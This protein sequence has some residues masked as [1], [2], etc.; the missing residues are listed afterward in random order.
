M[1]KD[2]VNVCVCVSTKYK[3]GFSAV[4]V[5]MVLMYDL[6][7]HLNPNTQYTI[8]TAQYLT[9]STRIMVSLS[10]CQQLNA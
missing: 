5:I 2:D 4:Y 8:V 9:Y 3:V 1:A 7:N 6:S 10:N